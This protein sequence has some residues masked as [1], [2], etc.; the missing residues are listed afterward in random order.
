MKIFKVIFVIIVFFF[1]TILTQVGGLIYLLSFTLYGT[2]NKHIGNKA[3]NAS[4][5]FFSFI[6]MYLI[7]TF[8]IVP[9]IAQPLGRVPLPLYKIQNLRPLNFMTC[10]LNRRYVR[11]QLKETAGMIAAQMN[12]RFPGTITNYLDAGFPFMDGFPLFP[13]LSHNDGK[14]L[15]L[16]FYYLDR[17]TKK[18]SNDA[19]SFIGYGVCEEPRKGEIN[20]AALCD[21]RGNWQY[22]LLNKVVSQQNKPRYIFDS[23]RTKAL[24]NLYT[25]NE[26]IG[27]VF[28][29]PHLKMRL[30]LKSDKIRFH[31]CG[32]VRHDDHIH[33]QL[34]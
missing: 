2:I 9:F 19:P 26:A 30:G 4:L 21:K 18:A 34:K 20:T 7:A 13:H 27:K 3:G 16:S 25:S 12:S 22:S 5:K 8:F 17:K 23:V 11:P 10:L 15:D 31:G 14:K 32:A 24:V 6:A 29:E 33:V 1:L 28:I